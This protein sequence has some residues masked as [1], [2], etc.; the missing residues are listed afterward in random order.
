M[1][2]IE[3]QTG[4]AQNAIHRRAQLMAHACYEIALGAA[5]HLQLLIALFEFVRSIAHRL[6]EFAAVAQLPFA[7]LALEAP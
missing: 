4:H 6:L 2:G 7:A 1:M 5:Q 3:Q